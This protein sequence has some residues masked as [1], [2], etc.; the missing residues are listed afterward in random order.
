MA[1]VGKT[2]MPPSKPQTATGPHDVRDQRHRVVAAHRGVHIVLQ[3]GEKSGLVNEYEAGGNSSWVK[4]YTV[5]LAGNDNLLGR[6]DN[7]LNRTVH[8]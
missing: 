4:A 7:T 5:A 8:A 2:S 1:T 3:A 6:T